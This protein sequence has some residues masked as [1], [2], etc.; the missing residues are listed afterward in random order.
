[1]VYFPAEVWAIIQSVHERASIS[2]IAACERMFKRIL[3]STDETYIIRYE[4]VC[5][6][7]AGKIPLMLLIIWGI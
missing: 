7:L 5:R 4:F 6:G 2:H 1:M 3:F